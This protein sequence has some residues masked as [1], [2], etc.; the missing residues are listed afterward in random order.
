M[1]LGE[2]SELFVVEA[3]VAKTM[4]KAV[5]FQSGRSYN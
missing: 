1:I 3:F 5:L 2:S 4:V